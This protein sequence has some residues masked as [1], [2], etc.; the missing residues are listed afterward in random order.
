MTTVPVATVRHSRSKRWLSR[1][2][3]LF[4]LL[5]LIGAVVYVVVKIPGSG[6]GSSQSQGSTHAH[7]RRPPP[8]WTVRPGD[9][10]TEIAH[11][12]GVSVGQIEAYNPNLDPQ[13]LVPGE[14]LNLWQHPPRPRPKPLGPRFWTVKPGESFGSIAAA[15]KISITTLF[16]LNPNLKPATLQPGDRVR[17][18]R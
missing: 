3:A 4:A 13:I 12:T 1:F 14:R 8:Y 10:L 6:T 11:A 9:T 7:A 2:V 15:T 16:Q 18:R 5:A 17:L